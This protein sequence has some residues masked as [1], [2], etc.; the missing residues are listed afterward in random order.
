MQNKMAPQFERRTADAVGVTTTTISSELP[1]LLVGHS[2]TRKHPKSYLS[3]KGLKKSE[4][5]QRPMKKTQ[6]APVLSIELL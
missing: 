6:Y 2:M 4:K 3:G 5:R 1:F